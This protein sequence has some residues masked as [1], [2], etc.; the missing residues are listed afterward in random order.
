M[1]CKV[2]VSQLAIGFKNIEKVQEDINQW[3]KQNPSVKIQQTTQTVVGNASVITS[4][5]FE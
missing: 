1:Q 4:I 5:F 2:I 3:L